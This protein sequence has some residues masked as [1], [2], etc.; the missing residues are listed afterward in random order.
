MK[1]ISMDMFRN[2]KEKVGKS[3]AMTFDKIILLLITHTLILSLDILKED[4]K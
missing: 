1:K 2:L 4:L 3:K